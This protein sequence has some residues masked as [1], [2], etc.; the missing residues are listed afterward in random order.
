[1]V[2]FFEEEESSLGCCEYSVGFSDGCEERISWVEKDHQAVQ[3]GQLRFV[4]KEG[5]KHGSID[6]W[7]MTALLEH[8]SSVLVIFSH[9]WFLVPVFLIRFQNKSS[10][11]CTA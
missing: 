9:H 11:I 3:R 7:R 6:S 8:L 5:S 10:C 1:M 2:L 4:A